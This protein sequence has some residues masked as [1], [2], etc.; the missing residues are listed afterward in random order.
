M[1]QPIQRGQENLNLHGIK[2]SGSKFTNR[3]ELAFSSGKR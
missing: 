3:L 2:E 1:L